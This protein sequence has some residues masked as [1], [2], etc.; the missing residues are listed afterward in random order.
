MVQ[1][2]LHLIAAFF[3]MAINFRIPLNWFHKNLN[4]LV[5]WAHLIVQIKLWLFHFLF[6]LWLLARLVWFQRSLGRKVVHPD[7]WQQFHKPPFCSKWFI[8]F[9]LSCH[10]SLRNL[11][12]CYSSNLECS[13]FVMV[14]HFNSYLQ[15]LQLDRGLHV[16]DGHISH[17]DVHFL[18]IDCLL[19]QLNLG[20]IDFQS[21]Y[22]G[23][24][25]T[26]SSSTVPTGEEAPYYH[27]IASHSSIFIA[28]KFVRLLWVDL[29][30][31]VN[32]I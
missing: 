16:P 17:E 1:L 24:S 25:F 12:W 15:L 7:H 31:Q 5:S 32:S 14:G 19:F 18:R 9:P 28:L 20:S 30:D 3:I 4:Q 10:V 13:Q 29:R 6:E 21:S 8:A 23:C 22:Q 11:Y 2:L 27:L 26:S